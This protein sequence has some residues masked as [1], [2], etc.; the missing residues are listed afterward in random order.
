MIQNNV[1]AGF[2][3]GLARHASVSAISG[4]LPRMTRTTILSRRCFLAGA[5]ATLLATPALAQA[6]PMLDVCIIGG[7]AAGIA[8][9]RKVAAS[10]RSY[11]LLEATPRLGGRARTGNAFGV[12]F[13]MGAASFSR[14][15]GSLAA[16]VEAAGLALTSL[17]AGQRLYVD[18]REGRESDYDAFTSALGRARRDMIASADSGRDGPAAGVL[19]TP[20]PWTATVSAQLGTLGCGRGLANVSTLDLSLRAPLPDDVTSPLGIGA[21]LDGLA[22]GLNVQFG[23]VATAITNAGRFSAVSVKGRPQIRARAIILA[24]PA[25]VLAAGTIR[26][27]PTLPVK[28]ASALRACPAGLLEHV[29]FLMPGNPLDLGTDETILAKVGTAPPATLRARINGTDLHVLHFGDA[30]AREIADKGEAAALKLTQ[31]FMTGAF[32]SA[33]HGID[34]VECSNWSSDP[35]IRGAMIVALPGQGAQRRQFADPA[36]RIFLAG[37]YTSATQWG[38][39]T[40][41]WNSGEIAAERAIRL[42]GGPA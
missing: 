34:K 7:G 31:A 10:G 23:A 12:P 38:T 40:G 29:A 6:A 39:L 28:L 18:G 13:D 19:K 24:V 1:L 16:T 5:S 36:G 8:A 26:F 14:N 3:A 35:L 37:E 2:F 22:T 21:V 30:Q 17:P 33:A 4:T 11:V 42:A 15:G 27:N 20:G 25:P 9:A 41:A 32:G